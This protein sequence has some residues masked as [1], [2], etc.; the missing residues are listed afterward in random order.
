MSAPALVIAIVAAAVV[1]ILVATLVA[2]CIALVVRDTLRKHGRWGISTGPVSC[3]RCG[4]LAPV[5]RRPKN[6]SQALWGGFTCESCG[7]E[8]DKW[9]QPTA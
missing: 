7:Q 3:P 9:G 4:T 5:V 2:L 1:V 8:Y 6:R